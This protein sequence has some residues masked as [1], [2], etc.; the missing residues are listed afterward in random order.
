MSVDDR[1]VTLAVG[2][3]LNVGATTPAMLAT[4]LGINEGQ[5]LALLTAACRRGQLQPTRRGRFVR[6]PDAIFRPVE[7]TSSEVE[8]LTPSTARDLRGCGVEAHAKKAPTRA[9]ART[10][11][12]ERTR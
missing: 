4:E 12:Q 7:P 11:N 3:V 9:R 10:L 8:G 6:A 5:A 2:F 1:A